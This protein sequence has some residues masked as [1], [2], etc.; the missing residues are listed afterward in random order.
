MPRT[1]IVIHIPGKFQT[2]LFYFTIKVNKS[3]TNLPLFKFKKM[4]N[5]GSDSSYF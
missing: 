3:D 1:L 2:A 5:H 4:L